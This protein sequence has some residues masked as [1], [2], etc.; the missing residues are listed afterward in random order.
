MG[1]E[2]DGHPVAQLEGD[3]HDE[4]AAHR[5]HRRRASHLYGLI[6]SGSVLASAPLTFGLARIAGAVVA[7]LVV[8]WAAE[9]YA[10]WIAARASYGRALRPAEERAVVRDGLPLVAASVVPVA[11]L[12]AEALLQVEVSRGVDVALAVNVVMLALVGWR[13]SRASG[14]RGLRHVGATVL[15]GLLGVAM[16]GLK[17]ALHH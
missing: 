9:T 8:Y 17:L 6:I 16:I 1:S 15:T 2:G 5:L 14:L 12:L 3:E 7:T 4:N 10:H 11:V 13:M